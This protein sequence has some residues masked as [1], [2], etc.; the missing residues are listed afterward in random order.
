MCH[1]EKENF[2]HLWIFVHWTSLRDCDKSDQLN[3]S[4]RKNFAW[5]QPELKVVFTQNSFDLN[6]EN[7]NGTITM[8]QIFWTDFTNSG[9]DN[10]VDIQTF[11]WPERWS[12]QRIKKIHLNGNA[13]L[14]F[15]LF[16][17]FYRHSSISFD[18][19]PFLSWLKFAFKFV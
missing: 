19:D 10:D 16:T 1:G 18:C 17:S 11:D 7:N 3:S 8:T 14:K 4:D 9:R 2:I 13:N 15:I 12:I 6:I 5:S